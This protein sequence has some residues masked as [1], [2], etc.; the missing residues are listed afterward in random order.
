VATW[1]GARGVVPFAA[2]LSIPLTTSSGAPVP[3]RDLV[4]VLA[5]AV[6]VLSLLAQGLHGLRRGLLAAQR[7]EL[8]RLHADGDIGDATRRIR[9]QLDLEEAG[10]SDSAI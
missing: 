9:R 7:D 8:T 2:A 3:G 1:A 10:L 5:A 6:I 4:L